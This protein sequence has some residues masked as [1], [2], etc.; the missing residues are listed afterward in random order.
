[1]DSHRSSGMT[2]LGKSSENDFLSPLSA[3]GSDFD[4][5]PRTIRLW[6]GCPRRIYLLRATP[7]A[8]CCWYSGSS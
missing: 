2:P 7:T 4:P 1:M 3:A 5:D 8:S 6:D